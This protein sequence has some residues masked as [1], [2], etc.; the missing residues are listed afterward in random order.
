MA[1]RTSAWVLREQGRINSLELIQDHALR[2]LGEHDVLV[3][4]Y[5]ASLNYREIVIAKVNQY[6]LQ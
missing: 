2:E 5:A 3:K 4:L 6:L 1:S